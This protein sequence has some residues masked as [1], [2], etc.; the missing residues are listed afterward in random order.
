M[1]DILKIKNSEITVPA[2]ANTVDD[3][4]LVRLI[5]T[6]SDTNFTIT[7]KYANG[8]TI[9]TFTIG[10]AGT[11]ESVVYLMKEPT[12]TIQVNSGTSVKGVSV[13]FY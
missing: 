9:G 1:A 5:N 2:T 12:E 6:S 3:A 13:A 10:F 4:S 8:D 7:Q 11:D